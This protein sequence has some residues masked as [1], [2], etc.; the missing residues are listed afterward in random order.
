MER[1]K[2]KGLF[3]KR[4]KGWILIYVL[5]V[6]GLLFY[7]LTLST[8]NHNRQWDYITNYCENILSEDSALEDREYLMSKF[9]SY[10]ESNIAEIEKESIP[11]FF[12]NIKSSKVLNTSKGSIEYFPMEEEFEVQTKERTYRFCIVIEG[13]NI[14][15]HFR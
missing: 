15:Y 4:K 14:K 10:M 7:L 6:V 2:S 9:N 13:N 1:I 8:F 3:N 5:I 11:V 12:E